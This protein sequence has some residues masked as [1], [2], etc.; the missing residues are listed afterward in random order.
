M[1]DTT[2][3]LPEDLAAFVQTQIAGG[4]YSSEV[5]VVRDALGMLQE[6]TSKVTAL[7]AELDV[8]IAQLDAGEGESVEPGEITADARAELG[9]PRNT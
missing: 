8:G 6:R 9:L 5:E 3:K 7:R 4:T 2:L 1:A